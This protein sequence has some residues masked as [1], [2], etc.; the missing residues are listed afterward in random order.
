LLI[1]STYRG[2]IEGLFQP[3]LWENLADP[4]I[5]RE[6]LGY[7]KL[8][9]DIEYPVMTPPQSNRRILRTWQ[10]EG[11]T[12]FHRATWEELPTLVHIINALAALAVVGPVGA[13][14]VESV[15]G[16]DLRDQCRL[17]TAMLATQRL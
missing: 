6:E 8:F 4:I 16:K 3:V 10:G 12:T 9:A 11:R 7:A 5:G 17:D 13:G 1:H 2:T 14:M 15:G